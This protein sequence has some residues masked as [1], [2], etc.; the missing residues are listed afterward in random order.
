LI[1]EDVK[2]IDEAKCLPDVGEIDENKFI[3]Y[4]HKLT[5]GQKSGNLNKEPRSSDWLVK[6]FDV[7]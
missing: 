5:T 2:L 1:E 6:K 3:S 4:I 7:S